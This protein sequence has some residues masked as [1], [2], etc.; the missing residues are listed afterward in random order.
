MT[1]GSGTAESEDTGKAGVYSQSGIVGSYGSSI[2]NFLR[3][4]RILRTFLN[5]D[6]ERRLCTFPK[7][8]KPMALLPHRSGLH[9]EHSTSPF[10]PR[11]QWP[12]PQTLEAPRK[13]GILGQRERNA[14]ECSPRSLHRDLAGVRG[15]RRNRIGQKKGTCTVCTRLVSGGSD[16][17]E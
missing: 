1:S 9:C 11:R 14:R 17:T 10:L 2:F 6:S 5:R 7:L 13:M 3:V 16:C 15:E 12:A 8:Q 4:F